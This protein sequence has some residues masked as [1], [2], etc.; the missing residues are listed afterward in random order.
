M[1]LISWNVNGLRAAVTKGFYDFYNKMDA[2][3]FCI[4]ETK[5]QLNQVDEEMKKLGNYQFW[6]SGVRKG[7]SGTA[8][9]IKDK[10][11]NV[12]YGIND[13]IEEEIINSKEFKQNNIFE[14]EQIIRKKHNLEASKHIILKE[15]NEGR[16]LTC[17]FEKFFLVNCYVPNSKRELERLDYRVLWEEEFRL[18]LMQLDKIKPIIYCGDLNVAHEEIDLKNPSTNHNNAGFTDDERIEMT[19]L[20]QAGFVDSFRYMYPEK[21]DAY[22]WWS[23]MFHAREKNVGW[24]IDYFI[25][26]DRLKDKIID[27]KIY[28]E[29][30][31]SD[32]CPIEL[33]IDI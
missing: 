2:D 32:H 15:N 14:Q 26:S 24:R 23:Y 3:V 12:E 27:A 16:I 6:N 18:Y 1:R 33:E 7:Y 31:G 21:T 5:M 10:P 30:M 29:I 20:L 22:T 11:I 19:K 25:V 13:K 17:E 4:Q 28:P 8:T 9:F